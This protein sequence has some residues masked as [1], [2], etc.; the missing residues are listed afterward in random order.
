MCTRI[1]PALGCS[2]F[3]VNRPSDEVTPALR[4]EPRWRQQG[5]HLRGRHLHPGLASRREVRGTRPESTDSEGRL[6]W[7]V[8]GDEP[9]DPGIVNAR[10]EACCLVHVA[11]CLG[12][13][14][15]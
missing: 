1:S 10:G 5:G 7:V 8:L 12:E 3:Y 14:E 2:V 4:R 15:G 6:E 13:A 9:A 11:D